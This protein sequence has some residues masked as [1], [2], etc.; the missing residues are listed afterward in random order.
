MSP[1]SPAPYLDHGILGGFVLVLLVSIGLGFRLV[2][3]LI[4]TLQSNSKEQV[5][6]LLSVER[7]VKDSIDRAEHRHTEMLSSF[8][9][10]G[11]LMTETRE[12]LLKWSN[13]KVTE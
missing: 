7:A 6:A 9:R 5:S 13:G 8:L 11:T 12:L 3:R 4:D 2:S 10:Y 1:I